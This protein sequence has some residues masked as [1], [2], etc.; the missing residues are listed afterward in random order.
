MHKHIEKSIIAIIIRVHTYTDV[1]KRI[2][3]HKVLELAVRIVEVSNVH[4]R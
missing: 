4:V 1:M 3:V 2:G